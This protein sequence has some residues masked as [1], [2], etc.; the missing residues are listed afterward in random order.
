V[1]D[2]GLGGAG[3]EDKRSVVVDHEMR[4]GG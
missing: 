1:I 3:F 2:G 4:V